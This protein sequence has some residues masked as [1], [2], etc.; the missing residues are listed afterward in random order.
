MTISQLTAAAALTGT[1][2]VP[3]VQGGQT[4]STTTGA[5]AQ[6]ATGDFGVPGGAALIGSQSGSTVQQELNRLDGVTQL[7]V[8]SSTV[9]TPPAS[10]AQGDSYLVPAGASG[11]W[12]A[13]VN[14]VAVWQYGAWAYYAPKNGWV[15]FD[16]SAGYLKVYNSTAAAWVIAAAG[17]SGV[18]G[19]FASDA[20]ANAFAAA[21]AITLASG[22]M[23]FSTSGGKLRVYNAGS[24]GDY[25]VTAQAAATAAANSAAQAFAALGVQNILGTT[26]SALP[27]E[28]TGIS[29][30][31]GTGSGGTAGTYAGGV[32]GGPSG[33]QW[34][35]TIDSTGK[36]ASYTILNPGISTSSTAPTLSLP[37]GGLTGATVPT[38]T[39]GT[40]P[41]NRVFSAPTADG[42]NIGA[43]GNNAGT[44]AS[45]PFGA[46]QLAMPLP[47]VVISAIEAANQALDQLGSPAYTTITIGNPLNGN[48]GA[49][50]GTLY[51]DLNN[52]V[53]GS[54]RLNS[55]TVDAKTAGSGYLCLV[56][57]SG[58]TYTIQ[59]AWPVNLSVGAN[60]FTPGNGVPIGA[61]VATGWMLAF[62]S[63]SSG[64][65]QLAYSAASGNA[66]AYVALAS[67][68]VAGAT[69][70]AATSATA[71][72]SMAAAYRVMTNPL[73]SQIAQLQA[74]ISLLAL[75]ASAQAVVQTIGRPIGST[76][77][78]GSSAS[79]ATFVFATP[80]AQA[81]IIQTIRLYGLLTTATSFQVALYTLSD[82]T[83][84]QVAGSAQT[85]SVS[86]GVGAKN[87]AVNI[88]VAAGQYIGFC[89]PINFLAYN[90][91][92]ASD[93][94]GYAG[95]SSNG[96]QS[97]FTASV[98]AG[99]Q[100]QIGFDAYYPA[101]TAAGVAANTQT[102]ADLTASFP[103]ALT[104]VYQSV[105]TGTYTGESNTFTDWRWCLDAGTQFEP[106]NYSAIQL[107]LEP[108][109]AGTTANFRLTAYVGSTSAS[110]IDTVFPIAGDVMVG[111]ATVSVASTG[112]AA[113]AFGNVVFP[114]SFSVAGGQSLKLFVEA[115]DNTG[116]NTVIGIQH[117]SDLGTQHQR[118]W[119]SGNNPIASGIGGP[120]SALLRNVYSA[121]SVPVAE[122]DLVTSATAANS[123]LVVSASG[124]FLRDGTPITFSGS[125]TLSAAP[126][127]TVSAGAADST[128]ARG[129]GTLQIGYYGGATDYAYTNGIAG[130]G[131]I[132]H[133][134]LSNLVLKNVSSNATLVLG[135][136][137][138]A[139]LEHGVVSLV[140][141]VSAYAIAATYS[142]AST[143]YDLIVLNPETQAVS[144]IP[145]TARDWDVAEYL[146]SPTSS[147]QIPLFYARVVGGT[148]TRLIPCWD[149]E[150]GVRRIYSA[151]LV[152]QQRFNRQA[153]RRTLSRLQRGVSFP[154]VGYG[155]SITAMQAASPSPSTPNG[156]YRDRATSSA[157]LGTA[158]SSD[159][160]GTV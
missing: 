9:S 95:S 150:Q 45:A 130:Y 54:G 100:V 137:Y 68:P 89:A 109:A 155:D 23:Y 62:W 43:W 67:A 17:A 106:G 101:V 46:T 53:S 49:P 14:A 73:P 142:W 119:F 140:N 37:S 61:S 13:Q 149:V 40:I 69:T 90:A 10:P 139:N 5:I 105:V 2:E 27:Y 156:Q 51:I 32:S 138:V 92:S 55:F 58:T 115:L 154:L 29:G 22:A 159:V 19:S 84:T 47:A 120:A 87:I 126:T 33:F 146:P 128:T 52:I 4:V 152:E 136:D 99:V 80:F 94:G 118:G 76:L 83:W 107:N 122:R 48:A 147:N 31:I 103:S 133:A 35:Y 24:W 82:T 12:A 151:D 108:D 93:S 11:V 145:G 124:T 75:A 78:T 21:N 127:G 157:Y 129:G 8:I 121:P 144:A 81:S 71:Y 64:G 30:G 143:R 34:T 123:G 125:V 66:Y 110:G 41:V 42:L 79:N 158:E 36:L 59:D 57:L 63:P 18:L 97:S 135:T 20:A 38:A 70:T 77:V 114:I 88:P 141:N 98:Q 102:I 74:S 91:S 39:V 111:Q 56:S 86:G 160:I 104:P 3:V 16:T 15:A 148:I 85:I 26:P 117:T 131:K 72:M 65:A 134:N 113:G 96:L 60:I 153:L 132:S 50:T 6:L 1:E 112:I 116:A 7:A 28:V 44:L 25:D